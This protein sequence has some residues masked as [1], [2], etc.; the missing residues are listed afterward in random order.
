[1][2]IRKIAALVFFPLLIVSFLHSQSV[3]E[4]AKKEKERRAALKGKKSPVITN[5]DL[6][7]VK[8]KPAVE[9]V[10]PSL[11]LDET[12]PEGEIVSPPVVGEGGDEAV[13]DRKSGRRTDCM[14]SQYHV[15]FLGSNSD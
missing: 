12:L 10:D 14:N 13:T 1:M 5:I 4:L 7:K 3:V 6:L 11:V 2:K 9:I 15:H 8:K